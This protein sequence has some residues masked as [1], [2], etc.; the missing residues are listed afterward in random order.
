MKPFLSAF[1]AA[2]LLSS[3][4]SA[5]AEKVA[6]FQVNGTIN[7]ATASYIARGINRVIADRTVHPPFFPEAGRRGHR[8]QGLGRK[9]PVFTGGRTQ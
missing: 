3:A 5:R 7:P 9:T 8:N 4:T 2:L 1:A 6:L